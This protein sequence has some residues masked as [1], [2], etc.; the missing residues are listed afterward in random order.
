MVFHQDVVPSPTS[1]QT[2]AYLRE[3]NVSILVYH[4]DRPVNAKIPDAAVMGFVIWGILKRLLQ[5]RTSYTLVGIKRAL[6][7][8]WKNS[9]QQVINKTLA[10]WPKQ[11]RLIYY[12]H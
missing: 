12:L 4:S 3:I 8:D 2:L 7:D 5:K 6:R 10:S 11:Y 1:K 9:D